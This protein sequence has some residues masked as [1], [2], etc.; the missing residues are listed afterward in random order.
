MVETTGENKDD[1]DNVKT[2]KRLDTADIVLLIIF[3][4]AVIAAA[5][6]CIIK[7]EK[8]A[9]FLRSIKSEFKKIVWSPWNQVRKNTIIVIVLVVALAAV[10]GV[11]DFLFGQGIAELKNLINPAA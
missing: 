11:L 2:P 6:V 10:I 5:I 3:G 9:K 7:R 8:V 4:V 1:K